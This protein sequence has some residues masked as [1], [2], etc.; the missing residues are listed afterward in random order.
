MI[1]GIENNSTAA[2]TILHERKHFFNFKAGIY[3]GNSYINNQQD[4][5]SAYLETFN[6]TGVMEKRGLLH[7]KNVTEYF[8]KMSKH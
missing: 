3:H 4:E 6:W 7:L 2:S 8:L 5:L 1:D